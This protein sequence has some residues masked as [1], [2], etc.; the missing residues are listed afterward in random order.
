MRRVLARLGR[1]T[2]CSL[3]NALAQ[4]SRTGM[5]LRSHC[6]IRGSPA[7]IP[8]DLDHGPP[9]AVKCGLCCFIRDS[10]RILFNFSS[11]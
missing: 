1:Q 5:R 6:G 4:V 11:E 10:A 9:F 7:F 8:I 3:K 2:D